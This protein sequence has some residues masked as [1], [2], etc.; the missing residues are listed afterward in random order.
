MSNSN[1][2]DMLTRNIPSGSNPIPLP[3][4]SPPPVV[5]QLEVAPVS[6]MPS[7]PTNIAQKEEKP[8]YKKKKF[9]MIVLIIA[10]IL[11]VIIIIVIIINS[12]RAPQALPPVYG[13]SKLRIKHRL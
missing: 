6:N 11:L 10:I 12:R 9:I 7:I 8:F 2:M 4:I 13:G 1:V 5:P 3:P